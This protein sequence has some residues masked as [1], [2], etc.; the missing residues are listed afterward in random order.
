MTAVVAPAVVAPVTPVALVTS[1]LESIIP[2]ARHRYNRIAPRVPIFQAST[3]NT[4]GFSSLVS[5]LFGDETALLGA[6]MEPVYVTPSFGDISANT[7]VSVLTADSSQNC[8]IC[9]DHMVAE[10][11]VRTIRPC[12]HMF[13]TGC[14][15]E[16]FRTS[17]RCPNCRIDIRR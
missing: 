10:E 13:H 12:A 7:V 5:A 17:V 2:P 14:I 8:A 3:L 6:D 16:W 15:D 4:S 9:Q 11:E 1:G